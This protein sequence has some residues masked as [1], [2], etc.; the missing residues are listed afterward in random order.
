MTFFSSTTVYPEERNPQLIYSYS[1]KV[2]FYEQLKGDLGQH[3]IYTHS[4]LVIRILILTDGTVTEKIIAIIRAKLLSVCQ[5][6]TWA[7]GVKRLEENFS[8]N[9]KEI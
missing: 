4:Q 3:R 8:F 5:Q 6:L 9:V 1:I 7:P 2:Y